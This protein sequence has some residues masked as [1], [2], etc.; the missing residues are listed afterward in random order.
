MIFF[1]PIIIKYTVNPILRPPSHSL[2]LSGAK[3][4]G[5]WVVGRRLGSWVWAWV[6]VNVVGNKKVEQIRASIVHFLLKA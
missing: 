3:R 2:A 6:W 5:S 1:I 4:H